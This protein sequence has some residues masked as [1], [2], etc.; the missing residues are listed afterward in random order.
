MAEKVSLV[1]FNILPST[2]TGVFPQGTEGTVDLSA[3]GLHPVSVQ[4][5]KQPSSLGKTALTHISMNNY[6]YTWKN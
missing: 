3:C 2:L 1:E 4:Q 5:F 6:T